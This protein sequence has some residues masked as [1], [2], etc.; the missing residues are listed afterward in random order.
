LEDIVSTPSEH[1]DFFKKNL[2]KSYFCKVAA[3]VYKT[4]ADKIKL[5]NNVKK[6]FPE[7]SF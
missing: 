3:K 1:K 6:V 2:A 5:Y 4:F 7:F